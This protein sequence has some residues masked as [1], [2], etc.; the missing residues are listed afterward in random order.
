MYIVTQ[1]VVFSLQWFWYLPKSNIVLTKKSNN[2]NLS[3][4]KETQ[5]SYMVVHLP[6]QL[7]HA[8]GQ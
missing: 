5:K 6:E 8:T 4:I 3:S 1:I 7:L 2:A